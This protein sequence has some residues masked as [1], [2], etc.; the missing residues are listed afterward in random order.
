MTLSLMTFVPAVA[1]AVV[2][3]MVLSYK[4]YAEAMK[5]TDELQFFLKHRTI[6]D[7]QNRARLAVFKT[8]YEQ[9]EKENQT[10]KKKLNQ[11]NIE[12]TAFEEEKVAEEQKIAAQKI[13]EIDELELEITSI[14]KTLNSDIKIQLANYLKEVDGLSQRIHKAKK[15][16]TQ[17][18]AS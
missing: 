12:M 10:L 13:K 14:Q 4:I 17:E 6:S 9:L 2:C 16:I 18:Q 3:L 11:L 5:F 1:V 7:N 8:K 15:E